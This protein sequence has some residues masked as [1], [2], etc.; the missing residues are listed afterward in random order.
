MFKFYLLISLIT[1]VNSYSQEVKKKY[2]EYENKFYLSLQDEIYLAINDENRTSSFT[3]NILKIYNSK[4]TTYYLIITAK[5]KYKFFCSSIESRYVIL[6]DT[7]KS[8]VLKP[9]HYEC[10]EDNVR[11]KYIFDF[12]I[13]KNDLLNLLNAKKIKI[14]I[15][16]TDGELQG[17][18][19]DDNF[20]EFR[21]FIT[22]YV[23]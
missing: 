23:K 18:F 7:D 19:S 2:D 15:Y 14:E 4:D 17:Y 21:K 3:I 5:H 13:H 6:Y 1:F 12:Q 8:I 10:D 11:K 16:C 20:I 22:N 9:S